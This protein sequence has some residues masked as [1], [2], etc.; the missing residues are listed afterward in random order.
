[1]FSDYFTDTEVRVVDPASK[2]NGVKALFYGLAGT[3]KSSLAGTASKVEGFAP[4]LYIDLEKGTMPL[5]Q[6]ADLS[7]TVVVQ[8]NNFVEFKTVI[9]KVDSDKEFPFNTIVIDTIDK[10]QELI[11]EHW[12][13]DSNTYARWAQAYEQILLTI[14]ALSEKHGLNITCLTH[15]SREVLENIGSL[16]VG[17]S[18]EG[19]KSGVKLPS[20]FDIVGRLTWEEVE[21]VEA[22]VQAL[23][24]RTTEDILTKT[25]FSTMPDIMGNPTM[26][27]ISDCIDTYIEENITEQEEDDNE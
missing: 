11:I 2:P 16:M 10:L 21:G 14:N 9:N 7:K 15:E 22:P 8:P 6:H 3:G 1:M 5:I 13:K 19:K 12:S 27:K 20:I 26:Q 23:T 17:P 25:R 24:V 18:F 4:V